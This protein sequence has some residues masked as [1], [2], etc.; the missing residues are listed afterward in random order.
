MEIQISKRAMRVIVVISVL[1]AAMLVNTFIAVQRVN[2]LHTR[3]TTL[4]RNV[5]KLVRQINTSQPSI[6]SI[7]VVTSHGGCI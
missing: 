3:V 5:A 7:P 1:N 2:D 6:H 4:S